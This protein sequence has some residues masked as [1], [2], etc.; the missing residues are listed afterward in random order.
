MTEWI[1][2]SVHVILIWGQTGH[3]IL[4]TAG[5]RGQKIP[6]LCGRH[7]RKPPKPILLP[8]DCFPCSKARTQKEWRR[9]L[10][11]L[12]RMDLS[13]H[14]F[15][16]KFLSFLLPRKLVTATARRMQAQVV[17]L[18]CQRGVF[19]INGIVMHGQWLGI[20]LKLK[21]YSLNEDYMPSA[22]LIRLSDHLK[23]WLIALY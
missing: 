22:V 20:R 14:S 18:S 2:H 9:I 12:S 21:C 11:L 4:W 3:Y 10:D 8:C 16:A 23:V 6:K 15:F 17:L 19:R 7:I 13:P 1:P 5:R